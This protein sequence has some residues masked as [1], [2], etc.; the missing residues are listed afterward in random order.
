MET[1]KLQSQTFLLIL[2]T[3]YFLNKWYVNYTESLKKI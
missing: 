3:G 2:A 1:S